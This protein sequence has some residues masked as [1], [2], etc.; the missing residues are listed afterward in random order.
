MIPANGMW[1]KFLK[2][3]LF[4]C[5][6]VCESAGRKKT[7]HLGNYLC[8]NFPVVGRFE[9]SSLM[10]SFQNIWPSCTC[11]KEQ[12][13]GQDTFQASQK[14]SQSELFSA[15]PRQAIATCLGIRK[16]PLP[17]I[18]VC[19]KHHEPHLHETEVSL[20]CSSFMPSENQ[21]DFSLYFSKLGPWDPLC[22]QPFLIILLSTLSS[23]KVAL[24]K[25]GSR[26]TDCSG[27]CL[28]VIPGHCD[29]SVWSIPASWD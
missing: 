19:Y 15:T 1:N 17:S 18:Y 5:V 10:A 22:R 27:T 20:M 12:T 23:L 8:Q 24:A 29:H 2:N 26:T 9:R 14:I 28:F 13:E 3:L 11:G 6:H 16:R 21:Q 4:L 25:L 7:I